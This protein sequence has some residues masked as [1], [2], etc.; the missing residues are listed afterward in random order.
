MAMTI[1]DKAMAKIINKIR[2][3]TDPKIGKLLD[4]QVFSFVT[5]YSFRSAS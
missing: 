4:I 5:T 1:P 2:P 3:N